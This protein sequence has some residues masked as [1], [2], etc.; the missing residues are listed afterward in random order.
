MKENTATVAAKQL[1]FQGRSLERGG[2]RVA[3]R[4][5]VV[6]VVVVDVVVAKATIMVVA[7]VQLGLCSGCSR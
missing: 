7:L 4:I 5:V 6:V 3:C 1:Q 2:M